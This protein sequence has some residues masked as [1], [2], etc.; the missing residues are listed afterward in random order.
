MKPEQ[1]TETDW[2][3]ELIALLVALSALTLV[4]LAV[5]GILAVWGLSDLRN[6]DPE[7]A[8]DRIVRAA[9]EGDERYVIDYEIDRDQAPKIGISRPAWDVMVSCRQELPNATLA[10]TTTGNHMDWV[11]SEIRIDCVSSTIQCRANN[12]QVVTPRYFYV[13]TCTVASSFP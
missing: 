4:V 12:G 8:M 7:E 10:M 3:T 11:S 13:H 1:T 6:L 2:R 5:A 9:V